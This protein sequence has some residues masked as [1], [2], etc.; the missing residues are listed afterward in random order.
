MPLFKRRGV[1]LS[2]FVRGV[3]KGLT[4][5][6]QAIPHAREELLQCHMEEIE[7]DGETIYRPKTITIEISEGRRI[8]VPTYTLSQVNCIGI[9][10]AKIRCAARI[11]DMQ[12]AEKCESMTCGDHHAIFEVHPSQGGRNSFEMLIEFQ[13]REPSESESRLIESLDSM[14]VESVTD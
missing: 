14:V 4:D 13:Q 8:T 7:E 5:G 10:A 9:S 11:V 12:T 2:Q 3:V 6:Q 1:T